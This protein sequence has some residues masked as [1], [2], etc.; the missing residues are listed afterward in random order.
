MK[1][2]EYEIAW[3]RRPMIV[4]ELGAAHNGEIDIALQLVEAAADAGADAVK[5]QCFL[6][7]TITMNSDQPEFII[8]DGPWRG[9][10]LFELYQEAHM[11]R[12]WFAPLFARAARL[13]IPMFAS[14]F[15]IEDLDFIKQFDPP[16]Y[17]IA[18]CELVDTGLIRAVGEQGKPTII[19]TGMAAWND[20]SR[21][22][23]AMPDQMPGQETILMHCIAD[24]PAAPATANMSA[25]TAMRRQVNHVGF[26]DHSRGELLGI[27]AT[28]GGA[29][30]IEKHITLTPDGTGPDDGFASGP[31]AFA[32]FARAIHDAY[33]AMGINPD[34]HAAPRPDTALL[35][36]R[37]SLYVVHDIAE[38]EMFN[39]FNVRSIRPGAGLPPHMLAQ[40]IGARAGHSISKG[41]ALTSE[42]VVK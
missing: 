15:S 30:M 38:G 31:K 35:P 11:P 39:A 25:M 13:G 2:G 22:L 27:I 29:A 18:S 34:M 16:A 37:R 26:S 14:V 7:D 4:A 12:S 20:I 9:R 3:G 1:I 5:I 6:P 36:L 32:K 17:K 41:T 21:A 24:Y 23:A 42:M 40:V 28:V 33:D 8:P 19:S 10:H